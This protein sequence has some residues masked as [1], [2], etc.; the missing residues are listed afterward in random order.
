MITPLSIPKLTQTDSLIFR[1]SLPVRLLQIF[2]VTAVIIAGYIFI[3]PFIFNTF[4]P[5]YNNAVIYSQIYIISLLMT[6]FYFLNAFFQAKKMLSHIFLTHTVSPTIQI[7]LMVFMT[8]QWGLMGLVFARIIGRLANLF[9]SLFL[10][11]KDANISHGARSW[12]FI[13]KVENK[14]DRIH[15]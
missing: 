9:F 4:F 2:S 11:L 5:N 8:I 6:P 14:N 7:A 1:Q 10:T 3:A 12:F 15:K 13:K